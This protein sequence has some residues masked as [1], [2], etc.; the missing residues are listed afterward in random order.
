MK[1]SLIIAVYKDVQA[2]ELIFKSL[3][4]QTYK[5]F[6][7]IVAEDG[8]SSQMQECVEQA[9][10][11]YTYEIK[12]TT[13]KDEGVRKARSQ[14]NAILASSGEYLIFIDGDCIL[15]STFIAGHINT[16]TKGSVLSGRR[17]DL[18]AQ[19]S[20]KIRNGELES[21]DIE[22]NFFKKYFYLVFDKSV[23][24]EQGVYINPTGW[25]YQFF[26]KHKKRTTAILGCNFSAWREDVIT[27][28]GFDEGYG[29]SAVSD[30]MDW[31]WRFRAYGLEIRSCKNIANMMHLDHLAHNRG[32]ASH[33]VV[34]MNKNRE[35][36]KYVCEKGLN[37]H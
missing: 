13:Q 25:I 4:L 5:N 11:N 15:Y 30:D 27:L 6:E 24:Y 35:L 14:N 10:K 20:Q 23:K 17:I 26:L 16:A 12:H 8:E 32:D 1:V 31:D 9:R 33:Q 28:N 34:K 22:K 3:A 7:V 19:L 37:T 2:L 36:G 29:E 18:N 21:S